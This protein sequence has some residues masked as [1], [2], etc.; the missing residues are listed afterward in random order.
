MANIA[1]TDITVTVD[2]LAKLENGRKHNT[3]KLA[4][5]DGALT[6]AAGGVPVTLA[7]MGMVGA[8]DSLTVFDSGTSAYKWSYDKTNQKLI[9][10]Y[11]AAQAITVASHTHDLKVIG[12][13]AG[14]TTNDIAHY[15]T[16]ILG[17]EAATDATIAGSTSAT[18]GGVMAVTATATAAASALT[19][20]S[21]V[22]IAAQLLH[23]IVIGY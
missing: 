9:A 23:V 19:Q 14:S 16:D 22:A 17:K 18:K 12:G 5:G 3:L 6:Y 10:E 13:Q 21:T 20:P 4:F 15:A 2:K 11:V 7:Q 1:A 8:I